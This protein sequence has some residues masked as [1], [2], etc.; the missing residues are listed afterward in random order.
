MRYE[1]MRR[2]WEEILERVERVGGKTRMEIGPPATEE[3]VRLVEERLGRSLPDSFRHVLLGFS[4]EV[5]V[6]WFFPDPTIM[7]DELREV[8]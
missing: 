6:W 4:K 2:Q 5:E 3:E 1:K 7:P 8:S